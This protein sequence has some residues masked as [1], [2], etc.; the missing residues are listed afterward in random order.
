VRSQGRAAEELML[1]NTSTGAPDDLK[2]A[3]RLAYRMA[4]EFGFSA[5][6]G[7]FNYLALGPEEPSK[8]LEAKVVSEARQIAAN[9]AE[10]CAIRLREHRD[11]VQGLVVALLE[12]ETVSGEVV[13]EKI[14]RPM[15]AP[16]ELSNLSAT[17]SHA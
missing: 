4:G 17:A 11:A 16:S 7:A 2:H 1:G 10:R 9:A 5:E 12:Y 6:L 14:R 13:D 8:P 3:S 15:H